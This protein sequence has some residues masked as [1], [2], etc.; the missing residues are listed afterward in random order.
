MKVIPET[1]CAQYIVNF[2]FPFLLVH[3]TRFWN[4]MLSKLFYYSHGY[5]INAQNDGN[6]SYTAVSMN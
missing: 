1:R 4:K 6:G 3:T 2:I 5:V